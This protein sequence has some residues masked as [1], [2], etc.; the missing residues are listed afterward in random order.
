MKAATAISTA[1]AGTPNGSADSEKAPDRARVGCFSKDFLRLIMNRLPDAKNF[2]TDRTPAFSYF[3][4]LPVWIE[5]GA[6]YLTYNGRL[7]KYSL[8]III[9]SFKL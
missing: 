4:L 8:A 2:G 1:P 3:I 7:R 9:R 5:E 6:F